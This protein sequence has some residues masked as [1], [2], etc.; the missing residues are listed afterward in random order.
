[1]HLGLGM[2]FL[3]LLVL[4]HGRQWHSTKNGMYSYQWWMGRA[5]RILG[6]KITQYG[7]AHGNKVFHA[8]NHVSFLD[9]LVISS[10]TPARFLSKHTVRY[11]PIIGYLTHLSGAL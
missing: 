7:Q 11:W 1:M 4:L 10:T 6:L 2:T 5:C 8:S 3:I 9:I